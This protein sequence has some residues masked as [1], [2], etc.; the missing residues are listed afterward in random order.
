MAGTNSLGASFQANA[1]AARLEGG[2]RI[3]AGGFGVTSYAAVQA[4]TIDLP[5]YTEAATSG[6]N[7]FALSYASQ[8]ANTT[9]SELGS[10]FDYAYLLDRYSTL[11]VYLRAAWAH[12]FNMTTS[13]TAVFQSLPGSTF[14]VQAAKPARDGALLTA[15][16]QYKMTNGWSLSAKF[17][18]EFSSTT[19][20][21]A[22]NAMIRK[23]W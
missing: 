7:Q 22:G 10:R 15:G 23:E 6:S 11:T 5:S 20:V 8:T 13:A 17:D 16:A 14:I 12:D 9:R 1:F 2:Y 19:A 21:Y 3:P 4:Q 18:G